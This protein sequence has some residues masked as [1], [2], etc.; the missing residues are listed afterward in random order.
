MGVPALGSRAGQSKSPERSS[1]F[2]EK[3]EFV[4]LHEIG[5]SNYLSA[6]MARRSHVGEGSLLNLAWLRDF[7]TIK[8]SGEL[9][10]LAHCW[11]AVT[12]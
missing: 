8:A 12:N 11:M 3:F 5:S 4:G 9:L 7:S 1:G 6:R 2:I 10:R